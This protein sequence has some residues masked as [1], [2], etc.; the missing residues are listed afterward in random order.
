MREMISYKGFLWVVKRKVHD[1]PGV[2]ITAMKNACFADITLRK[3]GYLYFC[4]IV[5]DVEPI[6]E[7]DGKSND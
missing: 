1:R 7:E 2:D 6:I 5:E 3:Q 4:D